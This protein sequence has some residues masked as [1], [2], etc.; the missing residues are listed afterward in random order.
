MMQ[1]TSTATV[2]LPPPSLPSNSPR[3]LQ[4]SPT[5]ARHPTDWTPDNVTF[6]IDAQPFLTLSSST[7]GASYIPNPPPSSPGSGGYI[8]LNHW[9][10]GNAGWS[11]GPP[12]KEAIMT[13]SYV[14]A[15]F[16]SSDMSR[17]DKFQKGCKSRESVCGITAAMG[18]GRAIRDY[19]SSSGSSGSSGTQSAKS[20]EAASVGV[21]VGRRR[22]LRWWMFGCLVVVVTLSM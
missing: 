9:S 3:L 5:N 13:V 21:G 2:I 10:N 8:V 6:F 11:R 22:V 18:W 16:N 4:P 17:V 7:M 19:R 15:Y 20:S 14:K 12:A 1:F